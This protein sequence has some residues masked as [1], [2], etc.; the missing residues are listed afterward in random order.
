MQAHLAAAV[1]D[2]PARRFVQLMPARAYAVTVW[3]QELI[4]FCSNIAMPHGF[5]WIK[6]SY[7]AD[8]TVLSM[9]EWL[10]V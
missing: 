3:Q 9:R 7:K 4:I 5:N 8:K 1:D 6:R 10:C 2:R